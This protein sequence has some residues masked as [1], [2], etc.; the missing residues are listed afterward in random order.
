MNNFILFSGGGRR[1]RSS[2]RSGGGG[3]RRRSS[4]RSGSSRAP[5]NTN[6]RLE[7]RPFEENPRKDR[8]EH[9]KHESTRIAENPNGQ[10]LDQPKEQMKSQTS[11]NTKNRDA[12]KGDSA[13]P[14]GILVLPS[15]HETHTAPVSVPTHPPPPQRQLFNPANPD[16]P[17][18]V[19]PSR[20]SAH[21]ENSYTYQF[22]AYPPH[23]AN[24]MGE[25]I[26]AGIPLLYSNYSEM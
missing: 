14:Q 1:R 23:F 15:S 21:E 26:S 7:A 8:S 25:Q 9:S 2:E 19:S 3:R 13:K 24:N 12:S 17:I 6:W 22:T 5:E 10:N 20:I 18:M 16:K 4:E 11:D